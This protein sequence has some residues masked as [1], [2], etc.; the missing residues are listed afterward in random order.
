[1]VVGSLSLHETVAKGQQKDAFCGK[2]LLSRLHF[3]T[4]ILHRR[5]WYFP[6]DRF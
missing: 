5:G 4:Y 1:M 2:V 3:V 6:T